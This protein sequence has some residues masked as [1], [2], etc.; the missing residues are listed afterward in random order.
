MSL[1][2]TG[3]KACAPFKLVFS[4]IWGPSPMLSTDG[5]LYCLIF[6]DA[7]TKYIWFFPLAVKSNVFKIFL[8]F[9]ALAEQKFATKIKSI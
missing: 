1:G 7:Y 5:Y 9:Q 2:L 8:Q 4:D 6:M 3:H